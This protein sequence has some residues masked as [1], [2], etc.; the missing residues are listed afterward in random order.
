MT[1][2]FSW[3]LSLGRWSATA[4]RVHLVFVFF[5]AGKLLAASRLGRPEVIATAAWLGLLLLSVVLHEIGHAVASARFG[6]DP[7]DVN[8]WP[9]GNLTRPKPPSLAASGSE[10]LVTALAGLVASGVLAVIS[11]ISLRF[12]GAAF[13]WNPFGNG[14]GSSGAPLLASGRRRPRLPRRGGWDGSGI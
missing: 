8:L 7:E 4:I 10:A 6:T 3:S 11:A 5:A 1:D 14:E 12:I 2:P 13:I 9:L